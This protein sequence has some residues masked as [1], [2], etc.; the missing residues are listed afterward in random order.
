MP[1]LTWH[2]LGTI[3]ALSW[4]MPA[5]C[6]RPAS[7]RLPIADCRLPLAACRMLPAACRLSSA[8]CHLLPAVCCPLTAGYCL[9][10][11]CC[12][13]CNTDTHDALWFARHTTPFMVPSGGCV[14]NPI[15]PWYTGREACMR[16]ARHAPAR[17]APARH[18][19]AQDWLRHHARGKP[20]DLV[21][22]MMYM[23]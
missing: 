15:T 19:A 5:A 16:G 11:A 1:R 3:L 9:R 22:P 7:C 21:I 12:T 8:A 17:H 4:Y 13:T 14:M 18:G 23:Q 10:C 6:R 20:H 2:Y